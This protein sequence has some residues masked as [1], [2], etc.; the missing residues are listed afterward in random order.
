[1]SVSLPSRS[2]MLSVITTPIKNVVIDAGTATLHLAKDAGS[3]SFKVAKVAVLGNYIE[4]S[5]ALK[6]SAVNKLWNFGKFVTGYN[7]FEDAYSSTEKKRLEVAQDNDG[8][9]IVKERK[10]SLFERGSDAASNAVIAP[11][12]WLG[13]AALG[14]GAWCKV[15]S[16][17][18]VV[19]Q[20]NG[21][22]AQLNENLFNIVAGTVQYAGQAALL[23]AKA[24]TPFIKTAAEQFI[25]DPI[26]PIGVAFIGN[27]VLSAKK[28]FD[29]ID[30]SKTSTEK[31][32]NAAFGLGKVAAAGVATIAL[33]N[34]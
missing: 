11:I 28:D 9:N 20:C 1:M 30:K 24:S 27:A 26:L 23:A 25:K 2:E 22:L 3:V 31:I 7:N 29:A 6:D 10:A 14:H 13:L 19:S 4:Q 15:G 18:G 5:Q 17:L 32:V 12:K 34:R 16:A 8:K 33:L 21:Q